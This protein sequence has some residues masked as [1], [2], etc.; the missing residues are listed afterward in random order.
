MIAFHTNCPSSQVSDSFKYFDH[1]GSG[2][3]TIRGPRRLGDLPVLVHI[4]SRRAG[5]LRLRRAD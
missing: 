3:R 1:S 5:V 2:F 4:V